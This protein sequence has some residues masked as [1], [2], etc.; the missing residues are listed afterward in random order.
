MTLRT[1]FSI[2]LLAA[3]TGSQ[4][5]PHWQPIAPD[6]AKDAP[7]H[8]ASMQRLPP[9][10][11][12]RMQAVAAKSASDGNW[13]V[14]PDGARHRLVAPQR[15]EHANGDVTFSA[16]LDRAGALFP[17]VMTIGREAGFGH[18]STPQGEFRFESWGDDGWLIDLGHP[19]LRVESPDDHAIGGSPLPKQQTSAAT[20]KRAGKSSTT[21]IDVMFIYSSG[22]AAR[23]PG[24]AGAT[25]VNHLVAV[26]NQLFANSAVPLVLRLVALDPTSYPDSAGDNGVALSRLR[27]AM[28]GGGN[29]ISAFSNLRLRRAEVGADLV[30]L[31]R[32]HDIETRGSCGIAYLFA[33][34]PE[35]GVNVLSDGADSWSLCSDETYAHEVGHNLGAE[36]QNGAN[37][38]NAG[39]GTAHILD[40]RLHTVM[41]SFGSGHP[42]RYR[43]IQRFSNPDQLCGGRPCGVAN[44]SD[45]A[46]RLRDSMAAVAAYTA[47]TAVTGMPPV[48]AALDP[49]SDGDGV[50]DSQ[51]AFP[52]DARYHR[53]RDGDGVPDELDAFPDD[54]SEWADT[55]G[56]GIGDNSDPDIDGDGVANAADAFPTDPTE[57]ADADGDG[58]GD[59]A[60]AF[61]FER[62][63]WADTDG[64]GV[65]DN[66]DPDADGDGVADYRSGS[67]AASTDLLVVSAGT[68]RVLR[69]DGDTGLF[70]GIELAESHTPLAFGHQAALAWNRHQKQLYALTSSE[71]RRYDRAARRPIDTFIAGHRDGPRPGFPSGFPVALALAADG[72]VLAADGST[73]TLLRHDA[74]TGE[75][76][77]G[78]RFGQSEVFD[79]YPRASALAGDDRLWMIERD[80][81]LSEFDVGSGALLRRFPPSFAVHQPTAMA[82][83]PDA[84]LYIADALIN[85]VLRVDPA[86]SGASTVF[87][88]VGAGGLQA[89]T[90]LAF[91]AD[92]DLYVSDSG[93]DRILRFDGASG[94]FIDVFSRTPPG[95]LQQPRA[96]LFVP[97]VADR[98]PRDAERR[99]RPVA[100]GW[101]NPDR[102]GHGFDLQRIGDQ[103]SLIWYTFRADGS[104]TWYLATGPLRHGSWSAPLLAFHWNGSSASHAEVG[105]A[106]LDFDG[107]RQATFAWTLPD[108][109]GSEPI[110]P[111][112]VGTSSETQFPTAAWYPPSQDGWGLSIT[113]QG[114]VD[115]V[116][117][118]IYDQTGA[119]AWMAGA[120]LDPAQ[121]TRYAMQRFDGPTRCPG[122][123]GADDASAVEGGSLQFE[124]ID[125]DAARVSSAMHGGGIDWQVGP[126]DFRRVTES[127]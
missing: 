124:V 24:S 16:T 115:Y 69:L 120:T 60:D 32:P 26:A 87:V 121:P 108:S 64:D 80:G 61:P 82:V 48:P 126:I 109:Q 44:H 70:A 10:S 113:R 75:A 66:A 71:L 100:G 8:L 104:P 68:D 97:K 84:A 88:A 90:G 55:N 35:R 74:I 118:F 58:I 11:V 31:V 57:W 103:L 50:P 77:P 112:A 47:S 59:N 81:R 117:A 19:Q 2:A 9:G 116:I 45:N 105:Q 85:R 30:T 41:A 13:I 73:R 123:P 17:V 111:L 127:P 94:A 38:P 3:S 40:G 7:I 91:G 92:G 6:L 76:R 1:L 36:H 93:N 98:F 20:G 43:R 29:T 106:R 99:Y 78:G 42:D 12:T 18:W 27:D 39:F 119:P 89:P 110:E 33:N 83:G 79:Q 54:P 86:Q 102:L 23:Y 125:H 96:L 5:L 21:V 25:R 51:D 67:D 37:S 101:A 52:L 107:E 49:D 15:I 14:L 34:D 53:D 65:G 62:R 56:N 72:T 22:F 95:L 28:R 63:E 46:R 122:C 4:A 114:E